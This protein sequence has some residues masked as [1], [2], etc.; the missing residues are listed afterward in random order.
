MITSI[1]RAGAYRAVEPAEVTQRIAAV[2]P[3]SPPL[4]RRTPAAAPLT[5]D[6][7]PGGW[8]ADVAAEPVPALPPMPTPEQFADAATW[9]HWSERREVAAWLRGWASA[10]ADATG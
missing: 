9:L 4:P 10:T 1:Y 5:W 3:S 8:F 7:P 6:P 2:A